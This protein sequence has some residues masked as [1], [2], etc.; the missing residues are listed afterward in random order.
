M[1]LWSGAF[2]VALGCFAFVEMHQ[3]QGDLFPRTPSPSRL[4]VCAKR[5]GRPD[6]ELEVRG[7]VKNFLMSDDQCCWRTEGDRQLDCLDGHGN[8]RKIIFSEDRS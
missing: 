5:A 8:Y 4:L 7:Q 1:F 3:M 6:S 2:K